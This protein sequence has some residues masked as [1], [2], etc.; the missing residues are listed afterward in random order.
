MEDQGGRF[1]HGPHLYV[2]SVVP[3]L[4]VWAPLTLVSSVFELIQ[5]PWAVFHAAILGIK[6]KWISEVEGQPPLW[7][8][9]DWL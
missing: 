9:E 8:P 1:S 7:L 6:I 2:R 4:R 3:N 5:N